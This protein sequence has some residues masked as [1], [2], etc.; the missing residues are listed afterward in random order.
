MHETGTATRE[1]AE[2]TDESADPAI[3]V[4]GIGNNLLSDDG[5]GI[6]VVEGLRT[7]G[8][9]ANVTLLDGGTLS[10][11][12][13]EAVEE[14][15]TLIVVDAA[16]LDAPPGTVRSFEGDAMDAFLGSGGGRSVHEVSLLDLLAMARLRDRLPARRVLIGIQPECTNWGDVASPP[17]VEGVT[18]AT[19]M[20]REIIE[21]SRA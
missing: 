18:R 4:L 5:A 15:A 17:V 13:L 7:G 12:L 14:A 10:F 9:P 11:T 1:E 21:E 20:I 6:H 16:N 2:S 19:R 3:L 8:C